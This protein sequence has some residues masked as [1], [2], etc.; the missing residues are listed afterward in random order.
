M[1]SPP[2]LGSK[3]LV[4]KLRSVRS[5]VIAPANTGRERSNKIVVIKTDHTNKGIISIFIKVGFIFIMVVIKLIDPKIEDTP[6]KCKE[7]IAIST[8][9]PLWVIFLAKGG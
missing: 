4:L 8:A 2:P 7:K 3:K 6:A 1:G 9:L 5:I